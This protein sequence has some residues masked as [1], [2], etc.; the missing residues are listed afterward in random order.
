MTAT[1]ASTASVSTRT[2]TSTSAPSAERRLRAVL[3]LNAGTSLAAG[4]VGLA[5]TGWVGDVLG[6]DRPGWIRLV[7]AALV[8][9]A[10]DVAL[11]ARARTPVLRRHAATVS[12]ADAA[13]VVATVVLVAL[14]AFSTRGAV[15]ASVMAIGVADFAVLQLVFRRRVGRC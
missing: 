7:S 12:A 5:A 3:A 13:W 10:L 14:G 6:V 15:V 2:S 9:F 8:L 11:L 1:T 4:V